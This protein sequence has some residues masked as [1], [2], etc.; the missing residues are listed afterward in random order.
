M[1]QK[2]M[3]ALERLTYVGIFAGFAWALYTAFMAAL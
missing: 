2:V 3:E 1:N